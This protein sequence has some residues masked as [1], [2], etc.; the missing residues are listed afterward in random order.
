MS[1][2]EKVNAYEKSH[3]LSRVFA[4]ARRGRNRRWLYVVPEVWDRCIVS[5]DNPKLWARAR[6][7]LV[8]FVQGGDLAVRRFDASRDG[9]EKSRL[10]RLDREVWEIRTQ[11][12]QLGLRIF[13]R[14][15]EKEKFLG[16]VWR[17]KADVVTYEQ[18]RL[19]IDA[20]IDV[21]DRWFPGETPITGAHPD[22][23][24]LRTHPVP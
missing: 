20:C 16:L 23:Y 10:A 12:P 5:T 17:H 22:D 13:G 18:N 24:L 3:D 6:A 2:Q 9:D 21:W 1:M 7:D 8:F 4:E 19:A 14:F 11:L 15:Y